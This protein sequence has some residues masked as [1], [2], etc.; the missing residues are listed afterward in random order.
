MSQRFRQAAGFTT[1][2]MF[3]SQYPD[4]NFLFISKNL[5]YFPKLEFMRTATS[6]LTIGVPLEIGTASALSTSGNSNN[7]GS[8]F[9]YSLP[10]VM[11]FNIGAGAGTNESGSFGSYFGIGF[12]H[13]YTS[14]SYSYYNSGKVMSYN[15]IS[16]GPLIRMG[17]RVRPITPPWKNFDVSAGLFYR[18]GIESSKFNT[19]GIN[20]AVG[21]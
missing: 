13:T 17:I 12:E 21:L 18:K 11:D 16:D 2:A 10:V 14:F 3:T 6:S 1:S 19:I 15:G 4:N 7:Y 8:F 9:S 20:L 5:V